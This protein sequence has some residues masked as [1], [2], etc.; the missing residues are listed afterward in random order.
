MAIANKG[1]TTK[2]VADPNA[3]Y[4]SLKGLWDRN[5]A[6]ISGERFV[7]EFDAMVSYT[8]L[9]IP[10]SPSM[11]A[12]Q[13]AIFKS[14][15]ELPQ[16]SSQLTKMLVGGLLRKQPVL[17]L[18][19]DVP[20]EASDWINTQF[21]KD[22]ASLVAVLDEALHE[23]M[24]TSRSFMFVDHPEITE[25]MLDAM[26]PE[27]RAGIKPYPV[28]YTANDIINWQTGET[29]LG[30]SMLTMIVVK[31][32]TEDASVNE[33]HPA[34]TST[35]WVHD[36]DDSGYYRI[37]EYRV[38]NTESNVPVISGKVV[39]DYRKGSPVM[40]LYDTNESIMIAGERL[41][42]IP[43]Y[44]LNGSIDAKEPLITSIVDKEIALYNKISR[45]N[46]LLLGA[47]TYTPYIASDMG[48]EEFTKIVGAGLGAWFQIGE[49]DKAGVLATPTEAL[50]DM[51]DAIAAGIEEIA[52]LGV[53]MLSP[54]TAQSGVALELRNATQTATLGT[55][56]T[57]VSNTMS[58]V[59]ATMLNWRYDLTLAP[60][61][62]EFE[63]SA[64]FNPAPIGVEYLRLATEWYQ[65]GL[66][67]RDIW[68]ILLKNNDMI[69]ADYDD[70]ET[71]AA[72]NADPLINQK[73]DSEDYESR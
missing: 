67:S 56:N 43:A 48:D 41:K 2:T 36:L 3:E 33:F 62:I 59:I 39:E 45:R 72:I 64:D 44:P 14:E 29:A 11:T 18:P 71:I 34:L 7:K 24:V 55:L 4:Q 54:E 73:D 57:K 10:F 58:K 12:D 9:L 32:F 63:L 8:N 28:L 17:T 49:K 27:E 60:S 19:D 46:H 38:D 30:K 35:V 20:E 15:A 69:P 25:A 22:D 50:T 51:A 66:I 31:G 47:A 52:R 40:I 68:L 1:D 5:K 13:Y 42:Y 26:T 53:R 6:V 23:E 70:E 37:R 16:I 61:D 65:L 21:G